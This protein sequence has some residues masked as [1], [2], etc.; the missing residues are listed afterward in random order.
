MISIIFYRCFVHDRVKDCIAW[1]EELP[2]LLSNGF[3]IDVDRSQQELT[4]EGLAKVSVVAAG[5]PKEYNEFRFP[6]TFDAMPSMAYRLTL[7][8]AFGGAPI[9]CDTLLMRVLRP[10]VTL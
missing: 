10:Q 7:V 3:S 9:V 1:A 5:R 2:H 8:A 4:P 6:G